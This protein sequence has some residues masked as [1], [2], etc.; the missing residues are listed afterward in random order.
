MAVK[1]RKQVR[2]PT[3]VI[4]RTETRYEQP[5]TW[6]KPEPDAWAK[7]WEAQAKPQGKDKSGEVK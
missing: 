1:V 6:A 7:P 4:T 5:D 2:K 3:K